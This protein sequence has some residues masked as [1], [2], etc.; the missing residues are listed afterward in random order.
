MLSVKFRTE[1]RCDPVELC[2]GTS[3]K[4]GSGAVILLSSVNLGKHNVWST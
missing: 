1:A 2:F 3:F 4:R